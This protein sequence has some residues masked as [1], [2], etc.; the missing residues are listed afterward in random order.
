[1]K[2]ISKSDSDRLSA[3][4][5]PLIVGVVY[6][7][8]YDVFTNTKNVATGTAWQEAF[9]YFSIHLMA[10]GIARLAVPIFFIISGYFLFLGFKPNQ[11]SYL[12]EIKKRI[13]TLFVPFVFWNTLVLAFTIAVQLSSSGSQLFSGRFKSPLEFTP[14]EYLDAILGLQ[15]KPI[16]YHFWFIRDLI[17]LCIASPAIYFI[18]KKAGGYFIAAIFC[19]WLFDFWP[20]TTLSLDGIL[21][22]SVGCWVALRQKSLFA[23][24]MHA[25]FWAGAYLLTLGV[26]TTIGEH[27]LQGR[28]IHNLGIALG[29]PLALYAS[30]LACKSE[31]I[32]TKLIQLA[33][34]SFFVYAAHDPAIGLFR[35]IALKT[36]GTPNHLTVAV[37]YF[38][39]PAVLIVLLTFMYKGLNRALPK[40][41]SLITGGR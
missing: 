23:L 36:L 30:G 21:F 18:V 12:I 3:I 26:S 8:N 16:A 24:D 11:Q 37:L 15:R 1:M 33:P 29:I 7:H 35:K 34:A 22:F 14:Y 6:I 40:F 5:F 4:R 2:Q 27:D 25:P 13:K 39:I 32:R 19:F 9:A 28:F 17:V 31:S 41:T 20:Q 10:Q 38:F